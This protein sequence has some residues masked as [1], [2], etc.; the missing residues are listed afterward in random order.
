MNNPVTW[1][2]KVALAEAVSYLILLGIAMPLK[3]GWNMP[4]PVRVVGTI[5]GVLFLVFCHALVRVVFRGRW[6]TLRLVAV[7]VASLL[8]IVPFVMDR[9]M[10]AW[11]AEWVPAGG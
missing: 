1:L 5:H 11:I 7:F 3:Y 9:R 8:P 2:R 6:P 10:Q 4:D